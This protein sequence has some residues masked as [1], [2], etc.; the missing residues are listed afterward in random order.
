MIERGRRLRRCG[1]GE[2]SRERRSL[3]RRA[4]RMYLDCWRCGRVRALRPQY[5]PWIC[6]PMFCWSMRPAVTIR[7][8]LGLAIQLG[9]VLDLPTVGVTHRPLLATGTVRSGATLGDASTIIDA[10]DPGRVLLLD[11]LLERDFV[12]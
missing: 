5:A 6:A 9:A 3:A 2:S 12:L 7:D 11:W 1:A 8:A 10:A 4:R